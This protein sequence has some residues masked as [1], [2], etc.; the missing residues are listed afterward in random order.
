MIA[1]KQCSKC[2][3]VK[4][5]T[6]FNKRKSTRDGL[7]LTCMDCQKELNRKSYEWN[8]DK[9]IAKRHNKRALYNRVPADLTV[10]IVKGLR[11]EQKGLCILL[12]EEDEL[13]LDHAIPITKDGGSTFENCYFINK[14][15]N[16]TMGNKNIFEWIKLQHEFVQR[17]FYNIFVPMMADRNGMT[18]REYEEFVYSHFEDTEG[19]VI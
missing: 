14:R 10:D 16:Q 5:T 13:E 11:E 19:E 17:R 2:E 15:F 7:S 12:G 8:K 4:I 6:E 9:N 3:E 18:P 1:E